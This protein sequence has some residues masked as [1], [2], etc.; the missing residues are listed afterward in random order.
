MSIATHSDN[1]RC[2]FLFCVL[3]L[4]S[5]VGDTLACGELQN[6]TDCDAMNP[7]Q[8][9]PTKLSKLDFKLKNPRLQIVAVPSPTPKNEKSKNVRKVTKRQCFTL[10]QTNIDEEN[11]PL[12]DHFLGFHLGF[13]TFSL[14]STPRVFH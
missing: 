5:D 7:L 4:P 6:M 8:D 10:F 14:R 12:V 9:P 1:D 3:V 11:P 13:S 2:V